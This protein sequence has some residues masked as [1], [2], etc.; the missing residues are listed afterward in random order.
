MGLRLDMLRAA[1]NV[2]RRR[3]DVVEGVGRFLQSAALPD[4]GFAG[5]GSA[6]D[7][8]YTVFGM[9]TMA[10]LG[11]PAPADAG[12]AYL[13]SFGDGAALDFV[14]LACLARCWALV[15]GGAP[16]QVRS[17]IGRCLETCHAT[18]GGYHPTPGAAAGTAYAGF[19]AV[20]AY[21]D[22]E[23][24]LPDPA[25]LVRALR[26]LRAS[27]GG[28]ANLP[29]IRQ[30]SMP[31]TAAAIVALAELGEPLDPAATAWLAGQIDSDGG[32]RAMPAAPLPDLLSTATALHALA[33]AG[34]TLDA[35]RRPCR[36]F[37]E[38]LWA[39]KGGFRGH[40]TDEQIDC[41][42]TFYGLLALGHLLD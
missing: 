18:D 13:E 19:L 24:P 9:Q 4:G 41:E 30:S 3:S 20:G 8:Y 1:A 29:A 21:Q 16:A 7:L 17:A 37:V 11:V 15:P 6:S 39:D 27:D 32:W 38:S 31:A 10:A 25:G 23:T 5:R 2:R 26:S 34:A 36:R 35:I 14:H 33:T 28:Y 40:W 42:Y 22:I 12:R